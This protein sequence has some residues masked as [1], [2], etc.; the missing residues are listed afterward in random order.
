MDPYLFE[1]YSS[2]FSLSD[3]EIFIFP[4][5][6]YSTAL[7]GILSPRIW[8]WRED[9]FF[10]DIRDMSFNKK[11][12]RLKQYIIDHYTFNL[13][14]ETW[15]LT[16]KATELSR[17]SSFIDPEA[18][19]ESNAL[20]GYEGDKYYFDMDIRKHFGLDKY[21]TEKIPYWKT[22]TVEAMD[23]FRYKSGHHTGA[24]ECV[25]LAALYAAAL[26]IVLDVPLEDIF[27][28]ATPLHSQNFI[29]KEDGV[30]TNNRRIV[31]KTMWFNGTELTA[32]ARRALENEKVTL[33]A[34]SSGHI[35]TLFKEATIAPLEYERFLKSLGHFLV[36]PVDFEIFSNFLRMNPRYHV[37]FQFEYIFEGCKYYIDAEKLYKYEQTSKNKISDA[38]W[39]KFMQEIDMEEF[40]KHPYENKEVLNVIRQKLNNRKLFCGDLPAYDEFRSHLKCIPD[41]EPLISDLK[42]F[43]CRNANVPEIHKTFL[44][45]PSIHIPP[46]MKRE[47]IMDYLQHMRKTL[48]TADLAFSAARFID[49]ENL[50][51]FLQCCLKRNPCSI[52]FFN[53]SKSLRNIYQ[54]LLKWP[55]ES[56]YE[57]ARLATPDEVSNFRRG[58]GL[59]KA[60]TL[61]NLIHHRL[62]EEKLKIKSDGKK[63]WIEIKGDSFSFDTVKEIKIDQEWP[64]S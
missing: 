47:E 1:K 9:P 15:G 21:D 42:Q 3:M 8:R 43:V 27:M 11:I 53:D 28:M 22:E 49:A 64:V 23:A 10:K 16:D 18:L 57:E 7:A 51:P 46:G 62:P 56:I 6:M 45:S 37:Y 4:E 48:P 60:I 24:G 32:K 34:H 19:K 20:F 26:Y 63:A 58:D 44:E 14:L 41:S 29:A 25:S 2:A 33:V 40:S 39:K 13:D 5:L 50:I 55:S 38:S 36:Q 54:T 30:L 35:H 61:A 52:V 59:E 31:T 17:F 12:Q